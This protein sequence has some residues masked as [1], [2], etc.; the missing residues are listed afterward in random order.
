MD[1]VFQDLLARQAV[2]FEALLDKFV[3]VLA[4]GSAALLLLVLGAVLVSRVAALAER[5]STLSPAPRG[6]WAHPADVRA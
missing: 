1:P 4:L 2:V 5:H 3:T 6:R